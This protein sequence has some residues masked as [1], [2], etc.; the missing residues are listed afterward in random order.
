[1]TD[2][3]H[4]E[5]RG[6]GDRPIVFLH[7]F[8][9]RA[10]DW[11]PITSELPSHYRAVCPDLPGHGRSV[12]VEPSFDSIV[13]LL[14]H[15]LDAHAPTGADVVGYSMGGRLALTYALARPERCRSLFIE[16]SS[17]GIEAPAERAQRQVLDAERAARMLE[18]GLP[19]FLAEWYRQPLFASLASD[20]ALLQRVISRRSS[21]SVEGLARA[22]EGFSPGR[23]AYLWPDVHRLAMPITFVA[24]ALDPKYSEIGSRL[25]QELPHLRLRIIPDAGHNVHIERPRAYLQALNEHLDATL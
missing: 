11:L 17:P 6:S 13:T 20:E 15:V 22:V 24:G 1:V 19:A 23:Q 9:G 25:Q 12:T 2:R 14:D 16:S 5:Q 21:G 8:L 7:G 18:V 4:I 10:Q 3:L